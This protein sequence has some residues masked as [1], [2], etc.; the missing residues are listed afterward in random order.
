MRA[1]FLIVFFLAVSIV[2]FI[3]SYPIEWTV[4][5]DSAWYASS[6]NSF[7]HSFQLLIGGRF[8]SHS[9]PLYSV[10]ISPAYFFKDMGDTFTVIKLINSL[11]MSSAI[12]PVFLLARRF[13]PFGRAFTVALLSVLIGPMFYTFTIMAENLHYP[14]SMWVIYL[15]YISLVKE[16][17]RINV[18]L[19]FV[20][21][22]A[23]LNKM[24]SLTLFVCY[25]ILIGLS[26]G[27]SCNFG[28]M[29]RLPINYLRGLF[30]YRYVF[31]AF[32]ITVL[33]YLIYRAM[34]TENNYT[35]PY[36]I[37]W[38]RFFSNIL[39]FDVIKY[40]KWFLTYLGQLNLSTGLFLFPLS[41]FMIV[42]LCKSDR[43][44]D[45]MFGLSV[46]ILMAG[47]LA[48][49]V[50]QSGYNLE[51]LT[52]RHFFILTPLIFILSFLWLR[53]EV[54]QVPKILRLCIG[55]AAIVATSFA[56]FVPSAT[57]WPAVDSAF[58]DALKSSIHFATRQGISAVTLKLIILLISSLLIV[59][60]GFFNGTI[61]YRTA[62]IVLFVFMFLITAPCYF[63]AIRHLERVKKIRS[64]V[65]RW[66]SKSI[67]SSANLVFLQVPRIL[68]I[69]HIIWN[70]DRNNKIYWQARERLENASK[71][72]FY[73]Y[74]KLKR[75]LNDINAT[76][77]ISPF[78]TY[79]GA[80][81]V[82]HKYGIDIFETGHPEGVMIKN[83]HI[84]FGAPY[85][86]QVLKKGWS[87]NEGT[88]PN[89]GFPTFVWAIGRE[90]EIDIYVETLTKKTLV[91]RARPY[92]PGQFV[93]VL[94]NGKN[95]GNI[96]A[97]AGWREYR[98][99]IDSKQLSPGKNCI[100]FKFKYA[101]SP[102]ETDGRDTRKL[103][104]AFDWLKLEDATATER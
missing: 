9:L 101:T 30:G 6:A 45:R 69:D 54:N 40:L 50:L 94:V 88:Y 66:I 17:S 27:I 92:S 36:T 76:Y 35:V 4:I 57:C 87:G 11:V 96:K 29:K 20:F 43:R 98:L 102:A 1:I 85:S 71:F 18:I 34:A 67:S 61:G 72:T 38:L 55:F 91:F 100:T 70:K 62:V 10:L 82:G 24:S 77:I 83:F 97:Q 74:I 104:M 90:S 2:R 13:M 23:V 73:D 21:G 39:D 42:S 79:S 26:P 64:P 63:Q 49:A 46:V 60:A 44:E 95:V 25:I 19:G 14:L 3:I 93:N 53:G 48:L 81:L 89:I 33:P 8:N 103:A 37:E 65:T 78:F 75:N 12:F 84:D 7:F 16:N 32:A 28:F 56:L 5:S 59:Y 99:S 52:E 15:M 22:L 47:V 31:V 80:N 51:R 68:A 41:T 86:R 58:I